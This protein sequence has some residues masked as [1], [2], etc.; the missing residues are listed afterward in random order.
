MQSSPLKRS[1]IRLYQVEPRRIGGRPI[2][3]NPPTDSGRK[4][5]KR[6]LVG[7]EVIHNQVNSSSGPGWQQVIHPESPAPIG[8]FGRKAFSNGKAGVGAKGTKPLQ[9]SIAFV[10]IRAKGSLSTPGFSAPRNGLQWPHFVKADH[11]PPMGTMTIDLNYSVFFTS[12]SGSLLS[13]QV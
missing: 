11:L 3:P 4:F 7:A 13:H 10:P 1:K 9:G 8:G 6:F 5:T 2:N 12:K